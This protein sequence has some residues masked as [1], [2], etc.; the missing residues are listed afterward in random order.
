MKLLEKDD[1]IHEQL[2]NVP[3]VSAQIKRLEDKFDDDTESIITNERYQY[4]SEVIKGCYK[5]KN[6]E[7]L[8]LSDKIDRVVTNRFLA[9][10]IFAAVMWLVYYIS[11]TTVGGMATDWAN[12][13]VFGDGWSLFGLVDVPGIPVFS[14]KMV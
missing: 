8:T 4:I 13:G 6:K 12:E 2:E 11:V 3:D 5:K 1:K 10:P 7:K 14:E 9:L